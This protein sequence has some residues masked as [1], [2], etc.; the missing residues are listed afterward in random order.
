MRPKYTMRISRLTV[1]KLGVKLYDKVSAVLAELIANAYDADAE[2]VT[3]HAPM[4]KYLAS[5]KEGQLE[6]KGFEIKI[7][8]D[9]AGMTPPEMQEFFLVIGAERRRDPQR[10]PVSERHKRKV[11]GRKGVGKLAPFGICKIMEVISAGG[12][13]VQEADGSAGFRTSHI[14][15][16]YDAIIAVGDEP[17]K[18]Y[19]PIVGEMDG[20]LSPASGTVIA[21]RNFDF[22]RVSDIDTLARQI[23]QRF[24]IQSP[25]WK[26]VLQDDDTSDSRVIGAFDVETMPN[27]CLTFDEHGTAKGPNDAPLADLQAGFTHDGAFYPVT[28]WMA[29][30]KAP[31]KDELMAGVRIY[32]NRKIAA[33]SM[34]FNQRAGFTGEHNIRSYLVGELHADWLDEKDD[35][36][37]TDRRDILWSNELAAGFQEWGQQ[38]VK[39][40]GT[41]S[42]D[43]MRR[44][45]LDIFLQTGRVE[46]RIR[47]RFPKEADEPIRER[48]TELARMFGRTMNRA[49]AGDEDAVGNLVDL[50]IELAPHVTLDAMMREA[51]EKANAPFDLLTDLLRTAR[52]AELSSF[53]RIADDRLKVIQRLETLKEGDDIREDSF[54]RLIEDA[55]W[56]V[57][58]EWAPV[59]ANQS[60]SSLRKEFERYYKRETGDTIQLS[61]FSNPRKR[62]DFVLSSQDGKAQIVEIKRP[63][64]A[65]ED[66]EM[67]RIVNYHDLMASFLDDS[68]NSKFRQFFHGFHITLVCDEL[69]LS[70]PLQA[71]LDGYLA[72][73]ALTRFSWQNFLLK[74]RVVHEAFLDEADRQRSLIGG[75]N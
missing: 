20:T 16:D 63:R 44:A 64:H 45:T 48:A 11:M 26:I 75:G 39:R 6:D 46:H 51:G 72:S 65:L 70:R 34:V 9:G 68:K 22:R 4:G 2:Q 69:S 60:L 42:R 59:T 40:V 73:G 58:P 14:I 5:K 55:P 7:E 31:Y 3:I 10:G 66:E 47:E 8:D 53:G 62:P 54:Q 57:N 18:P 1:D 37:Q 67:V 71:A 74:T 56:L 49:E 33:Q 41:L 61:D 28:G 30:S 27:T 38:V 12:D 43:P 15:L 29:Y 32:C 23:A 36:I 19:E 17:D 52:V 21:L 50:S 25:D 35:L 24:G 13:R